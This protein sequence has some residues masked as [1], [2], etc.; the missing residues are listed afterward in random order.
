MLSRLYTYVTTVLFGV[1]LLVHPMPPLCLPNWLAWFGFNCAGGDTDFGLFLLNSVLQAKF[2]WC[3]LR[4]L[5]SSVANM[6][7]IF[8]IHQGPLKIPL[9]WET[10]FSA[11]EI[12]TSM[13]AERLSF[14]KNFV[15]L[16]CF[17]K[18]CWKVYFL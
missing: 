1:S 3:H 13:K 17:N 12:Y 8:R 11:R 10:I 18:V 9:V 6:A 16:I 7:T 4:F 2:Y 14:Q 15:A 5:R